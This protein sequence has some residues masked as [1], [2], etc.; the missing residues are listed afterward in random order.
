MILL[1][2]FI[3]DT[4]ERIPAWTVVMEESIGFL[5]QLG[6][7][8]RLIPKQI[9]NRVPLRRAMSVLLVESNIQEA[10]ENI[11]AFRAHSRLN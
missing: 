3:V 11:P 10:P 7:A 1:K 2:T 8:A 5:V 9:H 4:R 6:K